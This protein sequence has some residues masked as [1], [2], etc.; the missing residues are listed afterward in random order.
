[1]KFVWN[2]LLM[3]LCSIIFLIALLGLMNK[4]LGKTYEQ[5]PK[6]LK[7]GVISVTLKDGTVHHFDSNKWKVVERIKRVKKPCPKCT[8]CPKCP[9]PTT[10]TKWKDRKVTVTTYKRNRISVLAGYGPIGLDTIHLDD[11]GK[12]Y[13]I[14]K[15]F[16][17]VTGLRYT[18][19][20]SPS[21]SLS[22]EFLT[23]HTGALALGWGW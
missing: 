23:N 17:P 6:V 14:R 10:V 19:G 15:E 8:I 9:K 22:I 13:E 2:A 5:P 1:M 3:A 4:A 11:T 16:G 12:H 18:R 7:D 20:L 21:W